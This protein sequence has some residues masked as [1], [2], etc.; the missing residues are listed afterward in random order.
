MYLQTNKKDYFKDFLVDI[1]VCMIYLQY[2][3]YTIM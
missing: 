3:K 1:D 2:R